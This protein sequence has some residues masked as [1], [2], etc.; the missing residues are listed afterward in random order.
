MKKFCIL[1]LVT[2][3]LASCGNKKKQELEYLYNQQESNIQWKRNAENELNKPDNNEIDPYISKIVGA[4]VTK[5]AVRANDLRNATQA[6]EDTQ[7]AI[8]RAKN[9]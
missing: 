4:P 5:G 7:L 8:E 9:R 2:F 3:V 6:I 1:F